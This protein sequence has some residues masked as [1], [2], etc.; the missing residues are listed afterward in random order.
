MDDQLAIEQ[1]VSL[2]LGDLGADFE[3]RVVVKFNRLVAPN[4]NEMV[5]VIWIGVIEFVMFVSFSQFQFPQNAH[6][7][8]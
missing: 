1:V 8:H 4:A 3:N 2:F 6:P 5:V 7:S